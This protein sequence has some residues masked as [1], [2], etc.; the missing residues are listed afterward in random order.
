MYMCILVYI[1][2]AV[3]INCITD[4]FVFYASVIC[5]ESPARTCVMLSALLHHEQEMSCPVRQ[6]KFGIS[7]DT[8]TS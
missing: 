6:L 1:N 2:Y 3:V 5:L 8:S 7:R 4:L